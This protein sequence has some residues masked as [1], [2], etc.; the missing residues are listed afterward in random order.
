MNISEFCRIALSATLLALLLPATTVA[1]DLI[2][3]LEQKENYEVFIEILEETGLADEIE[4]GNPVT[5]LAPHDDAFEELPSQVMQDWQDDP[6]P[7]RNIIEFHLIGEVLQ[8]DDIA[9]QTSM[10]SIQGSEIYVHATGDDIVVNEA[11][12]VD[13]DIE[14]SNGILHTVDTVLLPR[15]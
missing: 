11:T 6:E 8:A 1:E 12:I 14:F 4:E 5:V 9:G 2:D 10:P 13:R 15:H 7:V 3:H